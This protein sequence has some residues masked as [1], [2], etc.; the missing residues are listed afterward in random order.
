MVIIYSRVLMI[1][2][3]SEWQLPIVQVF[4]FFFKVKSIFCILL[5]TFTCVGG[6][7]EWPRRFLGYQVP[8]S[9]LK[10]NAGI[11]FKQVNGS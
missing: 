3:P 11:N 6:C 8:A 5:C 10:K 2:S 7:R 1:L 9:T 4:L